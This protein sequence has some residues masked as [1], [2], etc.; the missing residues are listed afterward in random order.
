M[1][2]DPRAISLKEEKRGSL[3]KPSRCRALQ[4]TGMDG[5]YGL[6]IKNMVKLDST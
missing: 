5:D 3:I 2:A 6:T 1:Y 4:L